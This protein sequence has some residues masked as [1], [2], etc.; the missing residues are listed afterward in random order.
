MQPAVS[1]HFRGDMFSRLKKLGAV[2]GAGALAFFCT[3]QSFGQSFRG[4]GGRTAS[5]VSADGSTVVGH[6]GVY[7][8]DTARPWRWTADR[9]VIP[10]PSLSSATVCSEAGTSARDRLAVALARSK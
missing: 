4:I 10:L 9:G 7:L 1:I 3:A 5:D 6:N 8:E 2:I